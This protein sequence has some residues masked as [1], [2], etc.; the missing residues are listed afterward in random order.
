MAPW[1]PS[2]PRGG[3][4]V[5]VLGLVPEM[6]GILGPSRRS[7]GAWWLRYPARGGEFRGLWPG[8]GLSPFERAPSGRSLESVWW[9]HALWTVGAGYGE[10]VGAADGSLVSRGSS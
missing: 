3:L 4:I 5:V 2:C 6:L 1:R 8:I 7:S 9:V 10:A